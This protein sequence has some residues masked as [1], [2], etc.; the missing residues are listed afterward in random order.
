MSM[1]MMKSKHQLLLF[2]NSVILF[3]AVRGSGQET[4]IGIRGPDFV[5][6][7]ADSSLSQSIA[8]TSS[9][10]DKIM[11]LVDPRPTTE[12]SKLNAHRQQTI[13]AAAA[14]DPADSDKLLSLLC[15]H[16]TIREFEQ[17][18]G[19]DVEFYNEDGELLEECSKKG[20]DALQIAHLARREVSSRLRSRRQL[21][22]CLLVAGLCSKHSNNN[23]V[24]SSSVTSNSLQPM[25]LWLDQYGSLQS[26]KYG[27]HGL[28][29]NFALCKLLFDIDI[30]YIHL[31]GKCHISLPST[32]FYLYL[33]K[34][35]SQRFSIRDIV[36]IFLEKKQ[37]H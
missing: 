30:Y 19:C 5:V 33:Y 7:G 23:E 14:G 29:S 13:L 9:N 18:I 3:G 27:A 2:I 25:L 1:T 28:G 37:L 15:S 10:L 26:I 36:K 22:V 35:E 11:V 12:A 8:L 31:I 20:V 16:C 24:L 34:R 17:G 32:F 21:Q 4:L 6:L